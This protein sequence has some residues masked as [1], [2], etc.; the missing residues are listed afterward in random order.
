MNG[1]IRMSNTAGQI[2]L[3]TDHNPQSLLFIN[4]IKDQFHCPVSI[5]APTETIEVDDE[6]PTLILMDADHVDDGAM[7]HWQDQGARHTGL[8]LTAF[9]LRDEEHALEVLSFMHLRG[10]FY[11]QDSLER[12]CKG[13]EKLF[14]TN[15]LWMSRSLMT[16]LIEFSRRQQLN[17]YRPA[18]GLTQREMEIIGLLGSGA[19][20]MEIAERLCVSEHTVKSHLYNVFKKIRVS[21]RLQAVNWARQNLGAP[22]PRRSIS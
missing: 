1:G 8:L 4:Y 15:D 10:V 12:I 9:N 6:T 21:N 17:A 11:R 22:P 20:N 16:R 3:V 2:V 14:G 18:C 13:I 7:Q 5:A 19:S